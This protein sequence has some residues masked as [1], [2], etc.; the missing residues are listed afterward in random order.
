M[1]IGLKIIAVTGALEI[2]I[3]QIFTIYNL[4]K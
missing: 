4:F 1:N 2:I 3:L